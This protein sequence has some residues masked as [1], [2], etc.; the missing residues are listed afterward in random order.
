[1]YRRNLL[2]EDVE[3]VLGATYLRVLR[4]ALAG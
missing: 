4:D 1:M 3:S 2:Q